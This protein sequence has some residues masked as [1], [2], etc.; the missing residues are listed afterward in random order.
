MASVKEL[1]KNRLSKRQRK[2]SS[3]KHFII[4]M[5]EGS[6]GKRERRTTYK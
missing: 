1:M 2:K 4:E 6:E 5:Q 3:V